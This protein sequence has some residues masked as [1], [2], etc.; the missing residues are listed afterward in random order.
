MVENFKGVCSKWCGKMCNRGLG[1]FLIRIGV[2]LIFFFAGYSKLTNMDTVVGFFGQIGIPAFLAWTVAIVE[3]LSGIL[4]ILGIGMIP[5]GIAI[6]VIM[7]VAI[8]KAHWNFAEGFIKG[9]QGLQYPL[10]LLLS[11][12]GLAVSGPGKYAVMKCPMTCHGD[13]D[14]KCDSVDSASGESSTCE[15]K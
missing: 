12:I 2:G 9:F 13:C 15:V 6:A 10:L 3:T 14:K 4:L 5:A 11:G 7:V 1:L 8:S